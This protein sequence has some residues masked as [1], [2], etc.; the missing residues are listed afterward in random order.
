M[1][2]ILVLFLLITQTVL[3][4]QNFCE[5]GGAKGN[6]L[7]ATDC[8][9]FNSPCSVE[10]DAEILIVLNTDSNATEISW[11]VENLSEGLLVA[12]N[13]NLVSDTI[14]KE[15]ICAYTDHCYRFII[16]DSGGDGIDTTQ[17]KGYFIYW[18][19]ELKNSGGNFGESDTTSLGACCEDFS[20]QLIGGIPCINF[21]EGQV[22]LEINGGTLPFDYLWSNGATFVE[23]QFISA[24][25]NQISV[26]VTD[27]SNC[28]D[29][30]TFRIAELDS[31]E[32]SVLSDPAGYCNPNSG[33]ASVSV[34]TGIPPYE[35]EWS[36]GS[37]EKTEHNLD[38]GTY[39][40]KVTDA[41]QCMI[42]SNFTVMETNPI[43]INQDS[44]KNET[45]NKNDGAIYISVTGG[46]EQKYTYIWKNELN[47]V[48]YEDEDPSGLTQGNYSV[49]VTDELGCS[50]TYN[51]IITDIDDVLENLFK[52]MPNPTSGK[53]ILS[54]NL[55]NYSEVQIAVY[56]NLGKKIIVIAPNQV[57]S[58]SF[59]LDLS[60]YSSGVYFVKISVNSQV[61]T[62]SI[63]LKR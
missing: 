51:F 2:T 23:K 22:Q 41:S 24:S 18:N 31:L 58:Q 46:T 60:N 37:K 55:N 57:K 14:Y 30:D 7:G 16:K 27:A 19:G 47:E 28:I 1:K 33:N 61:I 45:S 35:Y 29:R 52:L 25:D 59:E 12:S 3:H 11:Q 44:I 6:S 9:P 8:Y 5:T 34:L 17:N 43:V 48:V 42:E 20:V 32:L 36:S 15:L 10:Y 54:L 13:D 38:P 63:V 50:V 53:V 49:T 21:A 40:V 26:L 56:N 39:S 62:K 4:A